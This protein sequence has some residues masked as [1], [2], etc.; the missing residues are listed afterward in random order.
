MVS[1]MKDGHVEFA[2]FRPGAR[3]VR[4]AADFN[5]WQTSEHALAR[6][7]DGWWRLTMTLP[8]GEYRFKY[9][10]DDQLW[11]ADFSAYAVENDQFGGWNSVMWVAR[12]NHA[13]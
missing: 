9:L 7:D 5:H 13:G 10:I 2:Y 4:L 12:T 8:P 11:E 6:S 3:S 1:Q